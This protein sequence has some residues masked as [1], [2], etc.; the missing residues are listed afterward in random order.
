MLASGLIRIY[1][2]ILLTLNFD[3]FS[4]IGIGKNF[5]FCYCVAISKLKFYILVKGY[6]NIYYLEGHLVVLLFLIDRSGVDV[7]Y[8][9]EEC[10][11][12]M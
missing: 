4:F 12:R 8:D 10:G 11:V 3:F 7:V 2:I 1:K 5:V 6:I 9:D